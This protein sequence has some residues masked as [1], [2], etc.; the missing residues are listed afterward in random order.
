MATR[1]ITGVVRNIQDL[2]WSNAKILFELLAPSFTADTQYPISLQEVRTNAAGQLSVDLWCNG[3]GLVASAYRCTMPDSEQFAFT[4][5]AGLPQTF[6]QLRTLGTPV[7]Q[8]NASLMAYITAQIAAIGGGLT[9]SEVI[10]LILQ[11]G[12]S[13]SGSNSLV[14]NLSTFLPTLSGSL[15]LVVPLIAISGGLSTLLPTLS[16]SV[17]SVVPLIATS[18]VL[19]TLLP[20]LSGVLSQSPLITVSGA[21]STLLPALSGNLNS[22][23]PIVTISGG[24]STFLPTL[25]GS[26]NSVV[27]IVTTSG[28]LPTLLPTFSGVLSQ[29]PLITMSGVCVTL[30]PAVSGSL[31]SVVPIVTISGVLPTLLPTFSGVLSLAPV[32]TISG[33]LSTLLPTLSG[34]VS[35]VALSGTAYDFSQSQNAFLIGI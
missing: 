27:P 19:P 15:T 23:A 24:L 14:G 2:P 6:T 25:S 10:A 35:S 5:E 22:V 21:L 7:N 17:N 26:L 4:L 20:T 9:R 8:S 1:R 11:Y 30:L 12:G 18:G 34:S 29:S 33:G 32:V 13:G 16:G 3:S 28:V 31:N